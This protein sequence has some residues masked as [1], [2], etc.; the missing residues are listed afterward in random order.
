MFD[1]VKFIQYI[2]Y[3]KIVLWKNIKWYL[4]L[5]DNMNKKVYNYDQLMHNR[6]YKKTKNWMVCKWPCYRKFAYLFMQYATVRVFIYIQRRTTSEERSVNRTEI[7][8]ITGRNIAIGKSGLKGNR[9]L[10]LSDDNSTRD[11][12]YSSHLDFIFH[13]IILCL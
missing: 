4:P 5:W 2:T 8:D 12:F 7:I 1:Y 10:I 11:V 13:E 6:F 3:C 9:P